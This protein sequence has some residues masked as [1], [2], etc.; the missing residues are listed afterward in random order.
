MRRRAILTAPAAVSAAECPAT[1]IAYVESQASGPVSG[2]KLVVRN[3]WSSAQSRGKSEVELQGKEERRMLKQKGLKRGDIVCHDMSLGRR[4]NGD[5]EDEAWR[6]SDTHHVAKQ[7]T[8][9]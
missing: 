8:S 2:Q 9:T 6:W 3:Q 7:N 5:N 1:H 4:G